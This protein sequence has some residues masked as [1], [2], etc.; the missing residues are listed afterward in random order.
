MFGISSF[1][2]SIDSFIAALAGF[3]V[4]LLFTRHGGIG[5]S[6]DSVV[7]A[8]TAEHLRTNGKLIDYTQQAV[9]NFPAFY[10]FFLSAIMWITSLKPL[11]FAPYLNAFLFAAVIYITGHIM[12]Q[13]THRS[14]WYKVTLLS[15]IALSPALLEDYSMLWSE[16]IFILLLLLFMMTMHRYFQTH[17][18]K[19]LITAAII[20]ALACITRY[21]GVTIIAMGG[22]VLLMDS[23]LFWR[24]KL[25]HLLL[26]S[27]ISPSLL[28]INL[29][30]NYVVSGTLTGSRERSL[31]SFIQNVNDTGKAFCDWLPFFHDH[32]NTAT[33]IGLVIISALS[34]TCV[35]QFLS[36]RRIADYLAM[37][38]AFSLLYILFMIITA[39]LSRFEELNS[40][41]MSP[42]FIPLLWCGSYWL[43][44]I[45]QQSRRPIKKWWAA[46][47]LALFLGFQYNQLASNY[48][49]WDEVK[50]EG[51]PGYTED[52]WKYSDTVQFIEQD[53]LPFKKNYTIYSDAPDA[54]Y[55]F[56]GRLS[57]FLPHK[58]F[59]NEVQEFS[60]D[61]HC[62][63]I[64][65]TGDED[66]D[67][68]DLN[69]VVNRKKMKLLK[70]F[71]D[72][73][74]YGFED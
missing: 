23:K 33:W 13:F 51:I 29:T 37:S 14:K 4:I 3:T 68:V 50:D 73:A 57:K 35:Q 44:V 36:K 19:T 59:K 10:P 20:A 43:I 25:I 48:E 39:T 56:T 70:Q 38:A 49:T 28:I 46:A 63:L 64:W 7:Y 52:D 65:F 27:V 16:T 24:K 41:F 53:S 12:E 22:I 2:K 6:P 45:L 74:I 42:A 18:L 40:R 26:F 60:T 61:P 54:V 32:E 69:F 67:L 58:E 71:S 47:G 17:S 9:V 21:A 66:S 31:T 15:C 8:T 30:R 62:Y 1:K 55:F 5:I 34:F 11:V 72:G